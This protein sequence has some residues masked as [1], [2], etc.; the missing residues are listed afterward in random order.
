MQNERSL[1]ER[2]ISANEVAQEPPEQIDAAY[3]ALWLH[4]KSERYSPLGGG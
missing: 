4:G 2:T 1:V 3:L